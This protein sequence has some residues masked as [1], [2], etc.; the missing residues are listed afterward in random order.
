MNGWQI[1]LIAWTS[2]SLLAAAN[3]HG[4]VLRIRFQDRLV[5]SMLLFAML[6]FGGFFS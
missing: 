6:Y 5:S 3:A 4:K 2:I 1:A